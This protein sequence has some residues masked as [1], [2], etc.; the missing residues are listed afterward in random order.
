MSDTVMV[1]RVSRF[2][3]E[4]FGISEIGMIGKGEG[5]SPTIAIERAT[6]V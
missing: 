5:R 4:G 6:V 2:S 3:L 1:R